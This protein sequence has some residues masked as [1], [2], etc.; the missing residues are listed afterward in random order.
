MF[1]SLIDLLPYL[2]S[3]GGSREKINL[4]ISFYGRSFAGA[5]DMNQEHQGADK[6]K[7]HADEG[8]PQYCKSILNACALF[9]SSPNRCPCAHMTALVNSFFSK[10][11]FW[12]SFQ[13]WLV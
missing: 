11:T 8:T 10:I 6:A 2:V 13:I 7:W 4:G 1:T 12:P 3:G 9:F 5:T